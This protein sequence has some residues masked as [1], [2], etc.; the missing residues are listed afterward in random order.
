M[1]SSMFISRAMLDTLQTQKAA[2]EAKRMEEKRLIAEEAILL[3][4]ERELRALEEG[5][6]QRLKREQQHIHK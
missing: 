6:A 1:V 4:E 5:R 3:Q 2:L